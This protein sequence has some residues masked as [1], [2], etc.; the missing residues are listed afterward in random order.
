VE[1]EGER[2]EKQACSWRGRNM[3]A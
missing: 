1:T 2:Q 3:K